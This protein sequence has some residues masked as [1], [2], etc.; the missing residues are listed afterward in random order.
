MSVTMFGTV[1][2]I[3][4]FVQGVMGDTATSSGFITTPMMLGSVVASTFSG[5]MITKTGKYKTLA[6]SGF[7][8]MI[9]GTLLL[10][11]MAIHTTNLNVIINMIVIGLGIGLTMP[12]FII[13]VQSAF[14]HS[15]VGTVTASLQFFRNIGGTI[16]VAIL[17][18][19]LNTKF[20]SDSVSLI[21]DAVKQ[22]LPSGGKG[23]FDSPQ[24]LFDPNLIHSFSNKLPPQTVSFFTHLLDSLKGVLV[25]SI[26]EVFV[27][28]IG[29]AVMGF[30][31]TCF[32][33]EIPLRKR[34]EPEQKS[35]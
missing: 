19:I 8:F 26:H 18:S 22:Q 31:V 25:N 7:G 35:E 32:L 9:V 15:Q 33:K 10:S 6:L 30:L 29:I 16:G 21:P 28:S 20:Q 14:P 24:A 1:M 11:L 12:I 17:G 27:V 13:A 4:L 2:Y 5:L 23:L 34:H 3:P